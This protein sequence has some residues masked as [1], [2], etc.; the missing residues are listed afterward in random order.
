MILSEI[1]YIIKSI[2]M[3]NRGFILKYLQNFEISTTN[4][5]YTIWCI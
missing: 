1:Y 2:A 4:N 3:T 5:N